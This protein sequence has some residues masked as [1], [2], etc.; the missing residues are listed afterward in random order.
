MRHGR[1]HFAKGMVA[2]GVFRFGGASF[3]FLKDGADGEMVTG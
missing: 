3:I 1:F 2:Y